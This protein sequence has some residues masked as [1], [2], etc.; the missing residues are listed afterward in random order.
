MG[1]MVGGGLILAGIPSGGHSIWKSE[2]GEPRVWMGRLLVFGNIS[3]RALSRPSGQGVSFTHQIAERG[4][5][6]I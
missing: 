5:T 3:T 2:E 1:F 4:N 6:P